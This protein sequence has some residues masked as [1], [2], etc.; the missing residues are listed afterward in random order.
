MRD[1]LP[2]TP[3]NRQEKFDVARFT[4]GGN[5][6]NRTNTQKQTHKQTVTDIFTSCQSA[7]VD[8]KGP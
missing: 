3:T 6:R 1:S 5:I 2:W 7:C 4:L 8:N